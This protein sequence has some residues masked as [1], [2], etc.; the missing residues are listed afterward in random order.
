MVT[1]PSRPV[2][3]VAETFPELGVGHVERRHDV[4]RKLGLEQLGAILL[5]E[6][7]DVLLA[8]RGASHRS[9]L[10]WSNLPSVWNCGSLM[11]WGRRNSG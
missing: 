11:S 4:A 8:G 5:L 6:E 1:S 9:Y 10:V 7:R 3:L 2:L